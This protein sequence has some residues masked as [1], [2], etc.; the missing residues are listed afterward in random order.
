MDSGS[1]EKW[2]VLWQ[3]FIQI[4]LVEKPSNCRTVKMFWPFKEDLPVARTEGRGKSLSIL[5]DKVTN[6]S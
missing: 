6:R 2:Q 1:I 5:S 4:L 3:A